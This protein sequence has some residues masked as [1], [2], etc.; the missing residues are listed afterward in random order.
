MK[1]G[2]IRIT[3]LAVLLQVAS[4][5][6]VGRRHLEPEAWARVLGEHIDYT[7]EHYADDSSEWCV[8]IGRDLRSAVPERVLRGIGV[9]LDLRI[10]PSDSLL[11]ST[12]G[13]MSYR[14]E[15]RLNTPILGKVTVDWFG[16]EP[17]GEGVLMLFVLGR[18][19]HLVTWSESL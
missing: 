14:P 8:E 15:A 11:Q 4:W 10:R 5:L 18:W 7:R 13:C 2:L 9:E 17:A 19:I 3:A 16:V 1:K 6:I 12:S